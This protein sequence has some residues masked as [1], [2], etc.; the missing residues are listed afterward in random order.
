MMELEVH[1][2]GEGESRIGRL[3]QDRRGTIFFEYDAAWRAGGRELS[4]LY[5]PNQTVGAVAT[6]TPAFGE[7]HGLFQDALPDW[8]GE[9][10]MRRQFEERGIP[11]KKVTALRKLAC[12]GD[13]KMGAL[14]FR[15][16]HD[17]GDF[18]DGLVV[19][20][21]ELVEAARAAF[22]GE[23]G[24][25]LAGLLRTGIS[26]G[27]AQPKALLAI[28]DDFKTIQSDDPAPRGFGSWLVKFE[29]EPVLQEGRIEAAYA[30]MARAAGIDV[31]ET[32]L[33]EVGDSCHFATRRFDRS[34]HGTRLH[35]HSYSGLT[36]SPLR[37]GLEYGDLMAL[38]RALTEDQRAVE[39]IFRR[40][41]FN[42]AA[43]ND[44]DHGRNHAFLMD[45]TG[46][47][48][49]APAYDLTL[50]TYPL[51]SGFRAARVRG[52]A[53]A[54]SREDLRRLGEEQGVRRV[55]DAM[56]QVLDAV[57]DWHRHAREHEI[58]AAIRASVGEQHGLHE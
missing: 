48:N 19:E 30:A 51:A 41:V 13:R 58:S 33:L 25:V 6:A 55:N 36:H 7:L 10:L 4:P 40:A 23:S 56:D 20:L 47:W 27:G 54:I 14:G 45:G 29:T 39:E 44:D 52:K 50:A 28:S 35:L 18:N 22:R 17:A 57:A 46:A 2:A 16:D 12:Q 3:Y 21:G 32:R 24:D 53:A 5:L 26:P 11:W 43:A 8:W 1:W 31:A 37:E 49:V 15:P 38:A 34:H 9:R 42:V